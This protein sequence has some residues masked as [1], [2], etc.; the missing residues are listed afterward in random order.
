MVNSVNNEMQSLFEESKMNSF[1]LTS[2]FDKRIEQIQEQLDKANVE[3][4]K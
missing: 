4:A 2:N 1:N 3:H